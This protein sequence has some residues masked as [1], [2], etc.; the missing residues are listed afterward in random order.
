MYKKPAILFLTIAITF[1][2]FGTSNAQVVDWGGPCKVD[3]EPNI[4][5]L[6]GKIDCLEGRI[7]ILLENHQLLID[8]IGKLRIENR[9][10]LTRVDYELLGPERVVELIP[11]NSKAVTKSYWA[12]G[13]QGRTYECSPLAEREGFEIYGA[14]LSA[15]QRGRACNPAPNECNSSGEWCNFQSRTTGCYVNS[16]WLD[17]MKRYSARN[18]ISLNYETVCQ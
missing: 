12:K 6:S 17:W 3:G 10:A 4:D 5:K 1:F 13:T 14:T 8:I 15:E 16:D 18:G 9:E 11:A 2:A 7:D